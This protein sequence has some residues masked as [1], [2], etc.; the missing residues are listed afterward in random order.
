MRRFLYPIKF[1]ILVAFLFTLFVNKGAC[2]LVVNPNQTAAVLANTIAGPGTTILSPTLTCLGAA[3]GTFTSTGTLLAMTGGIVLTTGHASACAGTEGALVSFNDGTAGDPAMAPFL[4]AGTA[5]VDACILEFDVVAKSDT[6]G[7]NYQFGS[8]EYRNAVCSIYTDV[9]AFFISGPGIVGA[10][11]MALVPGT[12]IPVEINSVNNGG[13]GTVGGSAHIHCTSLGAGSPF[14]AYYIDNTGGPSL[15]YRGYTTKLRAYHT[16][17]PCDTY[18]LK[19]SIVD[20]GNWQY[21]SGVFLEANS[22]KTGSYHFDHLDAVGATI[23][24]LPNSIVKGCNPATIEV[25]GTLAPTTGQTLYITYGG[26]AVHG[27]D[28]T[29]PDSVIMP[30]TDTSVT[31][32]ITGIPTPPA[33]TKTITAYLHGVCGIIDS[34]NL[35]VID[36]PSA[37]ILTPDTSVCSASVLIRVNGTAG[38]SYLWTPAT[39]LSSA[40]VQQP[41]ATPLVTTT[42]TMTATLPNSGCPPIVRAVTI[43][44]GTVGVGMITPDTTICNSGDSVHL[45]V[46]G[47]ALQTYSWNPIVN[48][49]NPNIQDPTAFPSVT[50]TYTVTASLPGSGCE[51][52][53]V[54]V[55][56]TVVNPAD[57]ILTQDTTICNGASF[58]IRTIGTPGLT[59]TWTP[60]SGLSSTTSPDP[61]ANPTV[62]TNYI[63]TATIG[64]CPPIIK[65]I[66]VTLDSFNFTLLTPDTSICN[67]QSVNLQINGSDT[68]HYLWSPSTWLNSSTIKNPIATPTSSTSYVVTAS[69]PNGCTISKTIAINVVNVVGGI[70]TPD[71]AICI[72]K[73]VQIIATGNSTYAY[74]WIPT[75]GIAASTTLA[76]IIT[77]DTSAKYYVFVTVPGCSG[78]LDSIYID[79][80]PYPTVYVGGNR[81]L[82][83]YDTIHILPTV[84]PQWYEHYIY[85]WTPITNLDNPSAATV[86]F[87]AGDSTEIVLSVTTTAHCTGK[88][89]ALIIV[90]PGNFIQI[91]TNRTI[92]PGDSV[93]LNA[94]GAASYS[95]MPGMYLS[96]PHAP[97]PWVHAVTSIEYTLLGISNFGCKDTVNVSVNIHPQALVYLPDS[98]LIYP[99]ETY[100]I[101][102]Q[103]NCTWFSWFPSFGLDN[104]YI[105]DPVDS[106]GVS[107][108]YVV[109][110]GTEWGCYTTDSITIYVADDAVINIPNAFTPGTGVNSLFKLNRRGIASLNYFR[111]YNRWGNLVF[112]TSDINAGWDGTYNGKPQS[113]DVYVYVVEAV[114]VGGKVFNRKGNL[115]LLR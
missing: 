61:V 47:S 18:H 73:S 53:S 28:Y 10:V 75:A 5:T 89:S 74:Q 36:T 20:A 99:G 101:E 56:I 2:Q 66:V 91:D 64:L 63:L 107:M 114:M 52:A 102:P 31:F 45:R 8:E 21:D 44:I 29:G 85:S 93:Q 27:T 37:F 25:V 14:T 111:I 68:L 60:A 87:T 72:G 6:I 95:W 78:I 3:N 77:P 97:N 86:A 49:S 32:N 62:T 84:T 96:D 54:R 26:T 69:S 13:L 41:T 16:V 104:R 23:N 1:T 83:Q 12:T 81:A 55:T 103:T 39:G 48:L 43:T 67:G 42:Y 33:G 105:S 113:F 30:P 22:L 82:C 65:H 4:P 112:E 115:T 100:H 57:S 92:C 11:N 76:P 98:V 9:F 40:T 38:L 90:H 79:V 24:A 88:D 109:K 34:M 17:T 106:A 15:T 7:F 110:A 35:N 71:T 94:S 50:T 46:S 19:L 59:Y 58:T 70:T 51:P 80:Q 108:K